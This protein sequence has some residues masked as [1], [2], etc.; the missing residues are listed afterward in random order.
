MFI[1]FDYFNYISLGFFLFFS[2]LLAIIIA[3]ITI[4]VSFNPFFSSSELGTAYECGFLP[5]G[6]SRMKFDV[7]FYLV[8]ILFVIFD[9]EVCLLLPW[10]VAVDLSG[11]VG[12]FSMPFINHNIS[13]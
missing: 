7:Q 2:F 8:A 6:D 11:F 12:L 5:F 13:L 10:S 3:I 1:L 9:I 4:L